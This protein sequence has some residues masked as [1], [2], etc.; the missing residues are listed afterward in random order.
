MRPRP[1]R[2]VRVGTLA[3]AL[4]AAAVA[5]APTALAAEPSLSPVESATNVLVGAGAVLAGILA[6]VG[7]GCF[8]A[9]LG[10]VAPRVAAA[11]EREARAGSPTGPLLVGSLVVLG[12]LALVAA[13]AKAG[14]TAAAVAFVVLG[15]PVTALL[16]A[17]VTATIPLLGERLLGAGGAA[18]SPLRRSIVGALALGFAP[19]PTVVLQLHPLTFVV[20]MAALGWP[21]GVGLATVL[22]RR[23]APSAPEATASTS[24]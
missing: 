13:A 24:P 22:A 3:L 19:V 5:T 11:A 9:V 8:V 21:V 17:G 7:L 2:C 12:A 6:L 4:V 18:A 1:S 20:L 23:R 16:L 14:G 10:A 15:L